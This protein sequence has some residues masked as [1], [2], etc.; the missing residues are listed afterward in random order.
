MAQTVL[1]QQCFSE[2]KGSSHC[3]H[4]GFDYLSAKKY[5][6]ALPPFVY[7]KN[8]KYLLGRVLGRG[9]FGITYV[10]A[11]VYNGRVLRRVAIKEFMPSEYSNRVDGTKT[12][13]PY[14]D[15]KSKHVFEHGKMRFVDEART[16]KTFKGDNDIVEIFDYFEENNTAYIVM[17]F[18]DGRDIR[19]MAN[20]AGGK[21]AKEFA[22]KVLINTA[23]TLK[24]V[25]KMGILHRDISPDNIYYIRSCQIK[26]CDFGAARDFVSSQNKGLSVLLKH[27]YAPLE[28]YD[29]KGNQ[30]PWT[31]I[32]AL[33]CTYYRLVSGNPVPDALYRAKGLTV[34]SLFSLNCGVSKNVSDVIQKGMATKAEDRYQSCEDFMKALI[35]ADSNYESLLHP[36]KMGKTQPPPPPPPPPPPQPPKKRNELYVEILSGNNWNKRMYISKNTIFKIGRE[37]AKVDY[38]VSSPKAGRLHCYIE[39][40]GK[41]IYLVDNKSTNGTYVNGKKLEPLKK[42]SIIPGTKIYLANKECVLRID[43]DKTK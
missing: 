29:R 36:T 20:E 13:V 41:K 4:C 6:G 1:C 10:A 38:V 17:E 16:L 37:A 27:G 28:Q 39:Y 40:D 42:Y 34:N 32:Y 30:G 24:K 15:A 12:V 33:C 35:L 23:N 2:L 3:Y 25:H 19:T 31:D 21:V 7:L 14:A 26:L 11:E 9:G 43:I 8:N 22:D 5:K 18:L